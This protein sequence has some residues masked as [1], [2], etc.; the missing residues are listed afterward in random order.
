MSSHRSDPLPRL[1]RL[2]DARRRLRLQ[3]GLYRADFAG[4]EREGDRSHRAAGAP[5]CYVRRACPTPWHASRGSRHLLRSYGCFPTPH[6]S[7]VAPLANSAPPIGRQLHD[8]P[9][10]AS[11]Q[12]GGVTTWVVRPFGAP[13]VRHFP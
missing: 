9:F 6:L 4:P 11:P 8:L 10:R 7:G 2:G 13:M 5:G 3:R 1:G 12:T